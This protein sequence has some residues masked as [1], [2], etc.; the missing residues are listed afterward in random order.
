MSNYI[1]LGAA[2][3]HS[4]STGS[5]HITSSNPTVAP[6]FDPKYLSGK[7]DL[8]LLSKAAQYTRQ[9]AATPALAQYIEAEVEPGLAVQ[10]EA[11]WQQ[12]VKGVVRTEY[13]PVGTTA[14]GARAKGGVVNPANLL[15]WGTKNVRVVDLSIL[16]QHVS[17]HP[18]SLA[19]ESIAQARR[20]PSSTAGTDAGVLVPQTL[21]AN[22]PPR[23]SSPPN[24]ALGLTY[25][26]RLQYHVLY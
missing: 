2:L 10:T 7:T 19:C 23:L 5:I 21:S 11:Q 9:L 6:A 26:L 25:R 16:P 20:M 1:S 14:M 17:T 18:Q 3:Q 24:F 15:V 13:H 4:L 22:A 8:L 12:W